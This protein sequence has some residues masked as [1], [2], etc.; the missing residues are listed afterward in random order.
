MKKTC[1]IFIFLL[2]GFQIVNAQDA[3][4]I[5]SK[6][7]NSTVTI[8]TNK[9]LGSGFFIADN[10]IVTNYHVVEGASEI[11]CYS[12][13]STIKYEISKYF[14]VDKKSDL[15]LLYSDKLTRPPIKMATTNTIYP[16]EKIYVI[17]SPKG[18]PATISDG[19]I[20]GVRNFDE[21]NLI[22]IT[23]PISSGSSGGP[24]V[25][26]SGELVGVAVGQF[27][28]SQNLNFAVPKFKLEKLLKNID[29]N[30]TEVD[31]D[32]DGVIDSEDLCPNV[33]GT[34]AN[35]GCPEVSQESS[36]KVKAYSK[37]IY[38]NYE[39]SSFQHATMPVLQAI[40]AI[41]KEYPTA[42]ML[43]EGHCEC[44]EDK[45]NISE[46][47]ADS[48]KTYLVENGISAD[49]LFVKYFGCDEAIRNVKTESERAKNRRVV[50]SIIQ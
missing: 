31:S 2:F 35:N 28:E 48:V 13:N 11:Y 14:E 43:I 25:N 41:L 37:T 30:V 7:V 17:G 49:R 5:Y 36:S 33:K 3:K 39:K 27:E 1:K 32:N 24:V 45:Y 6:I 29:E 15:I 47:R 34:P 19:I 8:E 23:A 21:L 46:N 12:N 50:V 9:V 20:S 42:K 26:S 16:G 18:L 40:V 22:Q 10:I 4:Y 44:I 38:F